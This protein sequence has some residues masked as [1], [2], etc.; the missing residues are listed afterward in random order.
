MGLTISNPSFWVSMLVFG[1]VPFLSSAPEVLY[2]YRGW[3]TEVGLLVTVLRFAVG[4]FPAA[5]R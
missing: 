2:A 3:Q 4:F 1:S 5:G